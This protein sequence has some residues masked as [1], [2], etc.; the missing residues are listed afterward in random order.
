MLDARRWRVKMG[1]ENEYGGGS[2]VMEKIR[3]IPGTG[4]EIIKPS[5]V[6]MACDG[7]GMGYFILHTSSTIPTRWAGYF[8]RGWNCLRRDIIRMRGQEGLGRQ[9]GWTM[10]GIEEI[11]C[12]VLRG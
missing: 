1:T 8:L 7:R 10:A 2:L 6:I 5:P 3:I 9:T 11:L 4:S 12:C